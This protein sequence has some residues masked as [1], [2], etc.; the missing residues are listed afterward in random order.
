MLIYLERGRARALRWVDIV[1]LKAMVRCSRRRITSSRRDTGRDET[2][3]NH[4]RHVA[5]ASIASVVSVQHPHTP[6]ARSKRLNHGRHATL[7][8]KDDNCSSSTG[9]RR[10]HPAFGRVSPHRSYSGRREQGGGSQWQTSTLTATPRESERTQEMT[11][12]RSAPGEY[13]SLAQGGRRGERTRPRKG[14]LKST[15][16]SRAHRRARQAPP[17]RRQGALRSS[18]PAGGKKLETAAYRS[19]VWQS[20]HARAR[21][22]NT[23]VAARIAPHSARQ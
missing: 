9:F 13:L 8:A 7:N 2:R 10:Q 21:K 4:G 6:R 23:N 18:L 16:A 5:G 19:H 3:N 15:R 22:Q 12:G 17:R 11:R 14:A 1:C 20:D